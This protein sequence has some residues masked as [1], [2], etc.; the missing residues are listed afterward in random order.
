M[1][2]AFIPIIKNPV[3][4]NPLWPQNH[5]APVYF[6]AA[7]HLIV[8]LLAGTSIILKKYNWILAIFCMIVIFISRLYY[9]QIALWV[10]EWSAQ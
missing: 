7:V 1:V 8:F 5:Y 9:E 6:A 10:W 3:G 2:T 4:E